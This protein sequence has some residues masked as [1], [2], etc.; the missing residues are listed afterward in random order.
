M[1]EAA[2][3]LIAHVRFSRLEVVHKSV[4]FLFGRRTLKKPRAQT[5]DQLTRFIAQLGWRELANIDRLSSDLLGQ[6]RRTNKSQIAAWPSLRRAR[7]Q[8]RIAVGQII[9]KAIANQQS[10]CVDPG[11]ASV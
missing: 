7:R 3:R 9:P 11:L 2:E 4:R 5:I 6:L 1:D 10:R 8:N